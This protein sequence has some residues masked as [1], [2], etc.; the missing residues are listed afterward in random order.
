MTLRSFI[1]GL[2]LLLAII[3]TITYNDYGYN[4]TYLSGG[5]HFPISA[6]V[7]IVLFAL[8]LNPLLRLMNRAWVFGQSELVV[9]WC[10]IAAGIG[11]P[12]SGLMRYLLPYMVAP[13]YFGGSDGKWAATFFNNVPDWLVPSKGLKDPVVTLFYESARN[14]PIPW[15]AWIVPFFGWGI[16]IMAAYLMMFCITA[17]IRKQWVEH[18]RLSFPL[19]QIPLEIAREPEAGRAIN[20][21]FRS[22]AMWLGAAIPITFWLLAGLNQFY[23]NVPL[24]KNVNWPLTTLLNDVR[25]WR[26]LW[27]VYFMPVGVSFL[28]STEVSLSLWLF[29]VLNNVQKIARDRL[30]YVDDSMF[31]SRQQIGG[32]VAFAAIMLWTMRHHLRAVARKA[33]LNAKDVDDSREAMPYRSALI[34]LIVAIAVIVGWLA[35][36]GCPVHISLAFLGLVVVILLVLSRFIAQSGLLLVQ[37]TV[38]GGPLTVVQDFLGDKLITAKGMTAITFHQATLYGDTREVLMPSLLNNAKMGE[39]RLNLRKLF[40]VMM[41]AVVLSY[42]VAYFAQVIGYYQFGAG[43]ANAW[44]TQV[45]PKMT[46]DRLSMA[47]ESP[48]APAAWKGGVQHYL[49]GG[50]V[51]ALVAFLR[52]Y[53]SWWFVHPI[54]ILTAQTYPIQHLW[55][56]IFIGWFCKAVCQRYA[57][58][59]MMVRPKQFFL[60]IVIGDALITIF[61]AMVGLYLGKNVGIRTFPG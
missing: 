23:P 21:L 33:F 14:N 32:Y 46:L 45:Y 8:V 39:N 6:V 28:L 4:N 3:L 17:I 34:G 38:P 20:A 12:S 7:V 27:I 55:L 53:F 48:A 61:W 30:G 56:S 35:V 54:G 13:F 52:S 44:S 11:I 18:E 51:V 60:G 49:I 22:P 41:I 58:G 59:S 50:G 40:L 37:T 5:N 9:I 47:I 31:Q 16:V 26:G 42:S 19:A 10:I 25:G 15:K 57:R 29:F 1:V 43:N 36:I 24:I 2:L